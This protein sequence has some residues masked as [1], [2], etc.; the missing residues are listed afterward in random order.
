VDDELIAAIVDCTAYT[1]KQYAALEAHASQSD[2]T[3]FLRLGVDLFS[4]L[5]GH[6]TFIR[7]QDRTGSPTPEDDLFAGL[8]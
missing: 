6:E 1:A 3:F 4:K 7:A 2:S 5:M 8:R